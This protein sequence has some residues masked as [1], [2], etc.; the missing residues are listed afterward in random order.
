MEQKSNVYYRAEKEYKNHRE[1]FYLLLREILSNSIQAVLI[2]KDKEKGNNYT[3]SVTFDISVEEKKCIIVL[4]DNGEGFTENNRN[5]FDELDKKNTE[6][7][8]LHF[9]PLGQGRL[10]IVFFSDKAE[11]NTVFK[12]EQGVLKQKSFPYPN[13]QQGLFSLNLFGEETPVTNDTFTKLTIEI[14]KQNTFSRAKT[15][16]RK[17]SNS[18]DLKQWFIETF[19]PYIVANDDLV[20]NICY[21]GSDE[22]ITRKSIEI[23][24]ESIPFNLSIDTDGS[25]DFKLWLIKNNGKLSGD[26]PIVCFARDL[27]A[28]LE[29][30]KLSYSIDSETGFLF[31]L[32]ST[33]FDENVDNKGEKIEISYN[34]VNEINKKIN[35]LLD[36]RFKDIIK[37]NQKETKR[38]LLN[39]KKNYPS[40]EAF[41]PE[42]EI[43]GGKS[44]VDEDALI[45]K[46]IDTKG[47]Y[48]KKFWSRTSRS[49]DNDEDAPYDESEECQ[50]LLN[51]SLHIYVKHR[52]RVLQR[53][54]EMIHKRD[55]NGEDKPELESSVHEL[56]FR[57]GET[58][59]GSNNI[60]HLHNLWIL[61]DK[62]T[63]F[64]ESVKAKSTKQ[65]QK[66]SDVYIWADDLEEV[67]QLLILELKSTT[68]AHNAGDKEEG[69][70]AQV[71][72]YA[73]DFYNDPLKG[74]DWD[75]DTSKV[76]YL[77]IILARKSDIEKELTSSNVDGTYDP[78]P[79]LNDSF[80][81]DDKFSPTGKPRE[82]VPIRIELYSFEDIH[83]LA[84]SRNEVF[85]RLLKNEFEIVDDKEHEDL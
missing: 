18:K 72:R 49:V 30:G 53:L 76:Q 39:F 40:L 33:Y 5:C 48:E 84:S 62:F 4:E 81:K 9:H 3:P 16:F 1:K 34:A 41:V 8:R 42:N 11:Y 50:K 68:N 13:Q 67:K 63:T 56:L 26:N 25:Y 85:F 21:N 59:K 32:T 71:K 69:M 2:R 58:L 20:V 27:K 47:G 36:E 45:K 6:K 82:T 57:R 60:N 35:E 14:N 65:G 12:N 22:V 17:Y 80:Y 79:F 78:I 70:I 83:K 23:E 38:N 7:E 46:A 24:T 54:H 74:L 51:S 10:A 29:N 61:D 52:E 64:S 31:Y 75:V 28:E 19:F 77:G 43:V 55:E 44:V 66:L 37:N 15:F 73:K